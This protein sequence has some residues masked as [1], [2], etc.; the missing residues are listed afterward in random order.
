MKRTI[1]I[2]FI[3]IVFSSFIS[4][5]LQT[6]N[7]AYYDF[8]NGNISD[9][10]SN[11]RDLINGS[12]TPVYTSSGL[13]NGALNFTNDYI[14][15]NDSFNNDSLGSISLWY[16]PE[17]MDGSNDYI[18]SF[19]ADNSNTMYLGINVIGA[20]GQVG[21]VHQ[22]GTSETTLSMDNNLSVGNWYHIVVINGENKK[23]I[24]INGVNQTLSGANTDAWLVNLT[25]QDTFCIGALCRQ[26]VSSEVTGVIDE[27][28]IWN[29]TLTSSEISELYNS[30][31]GYNIYNVTSQNISYFNITAYSN[32]TGSSLT[33]FSAE[34]YDTSSNNYVNASSYD[35]VALSW[36]SPE[37]AFDE[38]WSGAAASCTS[39]CLLE[40]DYDNMNNSKKADI[41]VRL[42]IRDGGYY[43]IDCG[44]NYDDYDVSLELINTTTTGLPEANANLTYS[45]PDECIAS[46][47]KIRIGYTKSA[48][49]TGFLT[50]QGMD[51][52]SSTI[53]NTTNGTINTN[54]LS[55]DSNTY[56]ITVFSNNWFNN[57]FSEYNVSTNLNASLRQS[58]I[59]F[60]C[61][62]KVSN[63]S[64]IC[65]N[66][67]IYP[68]AG[69]YNFTIGV[70][71][72]TDVIQEETI[73]VLDNKTINFYNFYSTNLSINSSAVVGVLSN[74]SYI[75]ESLNYTWSETVIGSP[76]GTVGLVNGSYNI[77]VQCTGFA[78]DYQLVTIVNS[79]QGIN[80][81]LYTTNSFNFVFRDSVSLALINPDIVTLELISDSFSGNYSTTN[82]TIYVDL[83]SPEFYTIRFDSVNYSER[84]YY[85]SLVDNSFN[86]ITLYLLDN[87]VSSNVTITVTDENNKRLSGAYLKVLRYNIFG[88]NYLLQEIYKTDIE[89]KAYVEVEFDTE[90]YRFYVD[91]PFSSPVYFGS[92]D[93]IESTSFTIPVLL[94]T[95]YGDNFF[96]SLGV[97]GN[98]T[99]NNVTGNQRWDY[100]DSLNTIGG[101]CLYVYSSS[102]SD[103]VLINKS[104][105]DTSSGTIL[106]PLSPVN[107]TS[108]VSV[109]VILIDGEEYYWG[110]DYLRIGGFDHDKSQKFRL[111]LIMFLSLV[112]ILVF[113]F[114]VTLMFIVMPLPLFIGS[115]TEFVEFDKTI[116]IS[117]FLIGIIL[118]FWTN[119][120]G[121]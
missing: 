31:N 86:N 104:C 20:T 19:S 23:T 54:I 39:S 94:G 59:N 48:L 10:S 69:T 15:V 75:V 42:F 9:L 52:Y 67:T 46:N 68:D 5:N 51:F 90:F 12:N 70:S 113:S 80:F 41:K 89:G 117:F 37:N 1:L 27:V 111:S 88:N 98:I 55:N 102:L 74:C 8:D 53:Y 7:Q 108:Y 66:S 40:I 95:L 13:L 36:G 24:W 56:Y 114:D 85:F 29:R 115:L 65:V 50:E 21:V 119:R 2:L 106:I 47:I 87:G 77:T 100:S 71:G 120:R 81:S 61:F 78:Y 6:D 101:A 107:D 96:V 3:L 58:Q 62:E 22:D 33:N 82:G 105:T 49:D 57:S 76:D 14:G 121:L 110:E 26:S 116:S 18:L 28:S 79:T 35:N 60:S 63:D 118:A 25:N 72:Y 83:L 43:Y 64:L 32:W 99:F 4:A 91:Y 34:V 17:V 73:T 109:G 30:G 92:P 45:I 44:P 16:K 112:I 38:S 97:S 103:Y 84:F 11:N 93:Y